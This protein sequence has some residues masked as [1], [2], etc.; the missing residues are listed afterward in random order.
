MIIDLM[1]KVA[2]DEL[3]VDAQDEFNNSV[4]AD[5]NLQC[6]IESYE[7]QLRSLF[8][9]PIQFCLECVYDDGYLSILWHLS[10]NQIRPSG[11]LHSTQTFVAWTPLGTYALAL[12]KLNTPQTP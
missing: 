6:V 8:G 2:K 1:S 10:I 12:R 9:V 3:T 11:V 5:V 7:D 4:I